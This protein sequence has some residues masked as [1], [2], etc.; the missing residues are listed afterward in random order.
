MAMNYMAVSPITNIIIEL[1]STGP[2]VA[3]S[4]TP[5]IMIQPITY[6]QTV[7]EM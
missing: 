6:L 3:L 7:Y 2:E 1:L 4:V 5:D